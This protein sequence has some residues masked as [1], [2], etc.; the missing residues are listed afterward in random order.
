M[1][2]DFPYIHGKIEKWGIRSENVQRTLVHVLLNWYNK[3]KKADIPGNI[4]L[5]NS[6]WCHERVFYSLDTH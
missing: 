4:N 1:C 6:A 2:P 3:T 5:K